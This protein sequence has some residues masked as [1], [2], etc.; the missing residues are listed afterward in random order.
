[1]LIKYIKSVLWRVTER[2]S[3]I[4]DAWCLKVKTV[5]KT[6]PRCSTS[7]EGCITVVHKT[8]YQYTYNI[9][10]PRLVKYLATF[11]SHYSPAESTLYGTVYEA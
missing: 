10:T 9:I 3:Y 2:L 11:S 4:E 1:M 5:M 6:Q 8:M 7:N